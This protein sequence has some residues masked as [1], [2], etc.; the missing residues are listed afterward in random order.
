[1]VDVDKVQ[2]LD[3]G[4]MLLAW[5]SL[6]ESI[7]WHVGC[8]YPLKMKGVVGDL[9][10]ELVVADVDMAKFRLELGCAP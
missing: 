6:G 2:L 3:K 4:V 1:M 5:E 8:R 7:C 10:V 9:L